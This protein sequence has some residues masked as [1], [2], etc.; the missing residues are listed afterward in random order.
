[1]INIFLDLIREITE[2]LFTKQTLIDGKEKRYMSSL[3]KNIIF[4]NDL[5]YYLKE[6]RE[7]WIEWE[8]DFSYYPKMPD[9][10]L[11]TNISEILVNIMKN[12]QKLRTLMIFDDIDA[13]DKLDFE[14]G[15]KINIFQIWRWVAEKN[16]NQLFEYNKYEKNFQS[17]R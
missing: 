9:E 4:L 2:K 15:G 13:I 12:F 14:I 10:K 1:M 11:N 3:I 6:F 8:K 16:N 7:T 5:K 17:V